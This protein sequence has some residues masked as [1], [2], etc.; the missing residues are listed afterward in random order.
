MAGCA[1]FTSGSTESRNIWNSRALTNLNSSTSDFVGSF[2]FFDELYN[3]TFVKDLGTPNHFFR[4]LLIEVSIFSTLESDTSYICMG[5]A[6]LG[7][8]PK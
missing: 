3:A 4:N 2:S 1:L 5:H 6:N 7:I 8:K